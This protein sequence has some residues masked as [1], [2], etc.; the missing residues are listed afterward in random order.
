MEKEAGSSGS[1]LSIKGKE[2]ITEASGVSMHTT[3]L[4]ITLNSAQSR[5]WRGKGMRTTGRILSKT[6]T[7]PPSHSTILPVL[8]SPSHTLNQNH[9]QDFV[10]LNLVTPHHTHPNNCVCQEK[11]TLNPAAVTEEGRLS[12]ARE[13]GEGMNAGKEGEGRRRL[14]SQIPGLHRTF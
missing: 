1:N 6:T 3:R 8:P 7:A 2:G 12:E 14:A 4:E 5:G 10:E 13:G 9:C 11:E